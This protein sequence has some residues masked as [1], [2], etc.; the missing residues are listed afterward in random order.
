MFSK[1]RLGNEKNALVNSCFSFMFIFNLKNVHFRI[2]SIDLAHPLTR[3]NFFLATQ[4][5][6]NVS[7]EYKRFNMAPPQ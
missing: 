6:Q 7:L 3:H 5:R 1:I 2:L 4:I